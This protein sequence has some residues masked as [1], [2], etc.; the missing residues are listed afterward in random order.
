MAGVTYFAQARA[1]EGSRATTAPDTGGED[2]AHS[3]D[4]RLNALARTIENEVVPRLLLSHQTGRTTANYVTDADIAEFARLLVVH[5]VAVAAAFVDSLSISG[6][7]AA[8]IALDLFAP[9][10]RLLGVQWEEDCCDFSQVTIGLGKMHILLAGLTPFGRVRTPR[11]DPRRRALLAPMPGEQ[12][13]LGIVIVEEFF[14]AAGWDVRGGSHAA[15]GELL[16]CIAGEWFGVVG[17]SVS[18]ETHLDDVSTTIDD[19]RHRSLNRGV[20]ILV[21]GGIFTQEPHMALKVGADATARD[22]REAVLK[23][24]ELLH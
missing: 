3:I 12:H 5:D 8:D 13:T 15:V 19:I 9:A 21:G 20:R 16:D 14:R 7:A 1:A 23:A 22:A 2:P 11:H 4:G 10:A 17:L 18:G 24:Q 6:I